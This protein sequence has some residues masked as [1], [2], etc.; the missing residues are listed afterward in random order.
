MINGGF[1]DEMFQLG[2]LLK[3]HAHGAS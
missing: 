3:R 2:F 1:N